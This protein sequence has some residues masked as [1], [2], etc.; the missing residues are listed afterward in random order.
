MCNTRN[1]VLLISFKCCTIKT[2]FLDEK[3]LTA[4]LYYLGTTPVLRYLDD[5]KKPLSAYQYNV[6]LT[7]CG[8]IIIKN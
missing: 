5:I 2:N 8:E 7:A 6:S 1:V 4:V 3:Y